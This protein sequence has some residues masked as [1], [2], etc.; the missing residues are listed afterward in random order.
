MH[1][2][3][4]FCKISSAQYPALSRRGQNSLNFLLQDVWRTGVSRLAIHKF[5]HKSV[6]SAAAQTV[7]AWHES[8]GAFERLAP[9]WV[10]LSI[11]ERTG[12]IKSGTVTLI[13]RQGPLLFR[14][15]LAHDPSQ[16]IEGSQF[17]DFQIDG[18]FKSW[19][20]IHKVEPIDAANCILIDQVEYEL[21]ELAP[22]KFLAESYFDSELL[23]LFRY[24]QRVIISDLEDIARYS[25]GMKMKILVSGSSGL[26]GSALIPRLTTAGH[27]VVRLVRSNSQRNGDEGAC[28]SWD[29]EAG[30]LDT[31]SLE[32]FDAVIHLAGESIA[33]GRWTSEKK[34]KLQQSRVGPTKLLAE[35][36]AGLQKKPQVFIAASAIGFYG[37][38]GDERLNESGSA[39]TSFL[40]K[41]C[42][43]W[44]TATKPAADAGIRVVNLRTGVVL[45]TKGGALKQMLL[46]FQLGAGGQIGDGKQYFSWITL[47]DECGAIIHALN[48]ESLSG[49]VNL[50]APKPVTNLQFTKAL[51]AV[52]FRPTLIP[53]PNFGLRALFGEMADE[54]LISGQ[55]V[56]PE[57]LLE[58]GYKFRDTEIE[59]ALHH[60]LG[61]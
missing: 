60:V 53:I 24:R 51:G 3:R 11:A 30:K 58:S 20:Q 48:T 59:A 39:G 49:P 52:L 26:I 12:D 43:E 29:P 9:P 31:A 32:G 6:I 22:T 55:N 18:P 1:Y 38:R 7:F 34:Q 35:K 36:L 47:D 42:Q 54:L 10:D 41:L 45:S 28:L 50:T 61:K 14:W 44:E 13:I 40:S 5:E 27:T 21:P 19:S 4:D 23:R 56:V 25:G 15:K 33:D 57:K 16:F 37:P 8:L 17:R 2:V 46:P